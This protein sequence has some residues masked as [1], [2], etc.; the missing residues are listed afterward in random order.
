MVRGGQ[1]FRAGQMDRAGTGQ[2]ARG[3][4]RTGRALAHAEPGGYVRIFVDEGAPVPALLSRLLETQQGP[5]HAPR[6]A[7]HRSAFGSFM[8]TY[9]EA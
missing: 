4:R 7:N 6:D 1:A 9:A 2:Y 8:N 3:T 5:A